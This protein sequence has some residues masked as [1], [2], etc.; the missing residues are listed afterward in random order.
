MAND[1]TKQLFVLL[2]NMPEPTP[3][4]SIEVGVNNWFCII[5]SSLHIEFK[6]LVFLGEVARKKIKKWQAEITIYLLF[7]PKLQ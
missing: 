5:Q 3:S 2:E 1:T 7:S 4:I 6:L